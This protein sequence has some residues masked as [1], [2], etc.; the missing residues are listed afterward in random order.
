MDGK[1]ILMD[2]RGIDAGSLLLVAWDII[3]DLGS[4]SDTRDINGG[5]HTPVPTEKQHNADPGNLSAL[6]TIRDTWGTTSSAV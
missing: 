2:P 5:Y 6:V 1:G 4:F 3:S